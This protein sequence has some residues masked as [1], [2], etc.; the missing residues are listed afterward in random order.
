[1]TKTYKGGH[2]DGLDS[3]N[4]DDQGGK[5]RLVFSVCFSLKITKVI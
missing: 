4:G 5:T 3:K 2:Y 1:M